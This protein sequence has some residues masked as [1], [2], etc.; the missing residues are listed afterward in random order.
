MGKMLKR[1]IGE[2]VALNTHLSRDFGNIKAGPGR[3]EQVIVNLAVSSRDAMPKG[4]CLTVR[5]ENQTFDS[6][7]DFRFQDS[8]PA[9]GYAM[10]AVTDTGIGMDEETKAKIFE[11][12]FT[13]KGPGEGTGLGLATVYGIIRQAE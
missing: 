2:D 9:G 6:A 1:L 12:F 11:P 13:K 7:P 8:V 5:T 4:G 10:L 3:I